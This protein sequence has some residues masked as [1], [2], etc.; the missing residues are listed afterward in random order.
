M[1]AARILALRG[2]RYDLLRERLR[3]ESRREDSASSVVLEG[4]LLELAALASTQTAE[5]G[6]RHAPPHTPPHTPW[7]QTAIELI[8]DD[9]RDD[10]TVAELARE[11]GV[12]P[13]ALARAFRRE[14]DASP[15]DFLRWRKMERALSRLRQ[16]DPP[17]PIVEIA[18]EAGFADQ[19]S[20]TRACRHMLGITPAAYRA[21]F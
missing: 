11:L 1:G 6:R 20:F 12:H 17:L 8:Y 5:R 2:P 15:G 13:V 16:L 9:P 18:L 3:F 7:I 19:P 21:R 4:L 10:L 14:L